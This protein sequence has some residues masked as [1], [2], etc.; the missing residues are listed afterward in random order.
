VY[1]TPSTNGLAI[2]ALVLGILWLYWVGSILAVIFGH[3]ALSQIDH[4]RQRGR[5]LAIAG[6]VLGYVGLALFLLVIFGVV[7]AMPA[8]I[9]SSVSPA[10]P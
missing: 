5:G 10:G 6:L 4:S 1:A 9:H 7:L 3:I 2:A 8:T